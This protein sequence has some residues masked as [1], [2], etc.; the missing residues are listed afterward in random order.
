MTVHIDIP[1][2]DNYGHIVNAHDGNIVFFDGVYHLYG[3]VYEN[4]TTT[5]V[6]DP[7]H[8]CGFHPNRFALYTSPDLTSWA[9]R[10][11]NVL[12]SADID[13][14]NTTYW[15]PVVHR[16]DADGM[17]V[18]QFWSHHWGFNDARCAEL[19]FSRTALGPFINV[20]RIPLVQHDGFLQGL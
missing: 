6:C 4:C 18:M 3:T 7:Q 17:F 9:L 12:P 19:A 10:S 16:R 20:T 13:N 15:M 2:V 1:R 11:D 14:V 5:P 8:V